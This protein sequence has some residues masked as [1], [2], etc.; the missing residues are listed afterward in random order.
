MQKYKFSFYVD[1]F[2]YNFNTKLTFIKV[3][4]YIKEILLI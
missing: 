4:L 3:S 1:I 2:K